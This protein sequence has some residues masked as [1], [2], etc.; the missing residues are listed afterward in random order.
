MRLFVA[1]PLPEAV[2]ALLA[3]EQRRLA[4]HPGLAGMRWSTPEQQHL[5]LVFLGEVDEARLPELAR[6]LAAA[7]RRQPLLALA[8]AGLGAFPSARRASVLW[9][10]VAGDTEALAGLHDRL[11]Q[12]LRGFYRP[13]ARGFKPHLTL[14]RLRGG[15]QAEAAAAALAQ[16]PAAPVVRWVAREVDLYRSQLSREGARYTRLERFALG[17]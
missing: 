8:T 15:A 6:A 14:A 4:A 10:G 13:E 9:C 16:L 3:A 2:K 5:T 7:S 17:P 1:L 12:Q 11:T